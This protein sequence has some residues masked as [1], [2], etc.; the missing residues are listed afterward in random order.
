MR[1][2]IPSL[3]FLLIV[4]SCKD[5][6]LPILGNRYFELGDTVYAKVP[7]FDYMN[8]D[9]QMVSL[10]SLEGDIILATFF[11]TS[12]QTICPKVMRSMMRLEETFKGDSQLA[13]IC[14]SLDH[15]KDTIPRLK[16]YKSK[17][18]V[19]NNNFHLLRGNEYNDTKN[20]ANGFLSTAMDDPT[21]PG[22]IDHSGWILLVDTAHHI[23]S[24][25][26]G[27]DEKDVNRFID[28]IKLLQHEMGRH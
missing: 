20:I 9:S 8:Q 23:R 12:C 15:R 5:K 7:D 6:K 25:S 14:F 11:F 18:G 21:A 26:L 16:Q 4:T 24:F 27:T 10:K 22:G 3:L 17:L 19:Q 28:D 1:F 13:Y 2:I